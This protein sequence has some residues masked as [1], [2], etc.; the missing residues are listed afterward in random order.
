MAKLANFARCAIGSS[1][2][3]GKKKRSQATILNSRLESFMAGSQEVPLTKLRNP[4]SLKQQVSSKMSQGDIHTVL[5]KSK[6]PKK[7]TTKNECMHFDTKT[8]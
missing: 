1:K 5:P 8:S 2:R 7:N 6:K 3:G 4:P